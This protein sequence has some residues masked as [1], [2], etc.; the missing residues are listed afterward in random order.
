MASLP[1]VDMTSRHSG[2]NDNTLRPTTCT[3][4]SDDN[5]TRFK[6]VLVNSHELT[7]QETPRA[8]Q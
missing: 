7:K 8:G 6:T 4:G 2:S 3:T 1:N 5:D